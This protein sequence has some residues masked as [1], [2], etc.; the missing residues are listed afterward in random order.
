MSIESAKKEFM[1]AIQAAG[2]F[3]SMTLGSTLHVFCGDNAAKVEADLRKQ[4]IRTGETLVK[5]GVK[6]YYDWV[7]IYD[8][9]K[10]G[11]DCY[12]WHADGNR[13]KHNLVHTIIRGDVQEKHIIKSAFRVPEAI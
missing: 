10:S 11:S 12:V 13:V 1:D 5:D 2:G 8:T 3:R 9:S 7:A 4:A 6:E